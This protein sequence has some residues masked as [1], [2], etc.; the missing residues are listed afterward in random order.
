MIVKQFTKWIRGLFKQEEI[1]G[2]IPEESALV[3][4]NCNL[5]IAGKIFRRPGYKDWDDETDGSQV[6][7]S[8]GLPSFNPTN[9]IKLFT[10]LF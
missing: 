8:D 4:H 5:D 1:E 6:A 9:F 2:R 10:Y 7:A 3:L